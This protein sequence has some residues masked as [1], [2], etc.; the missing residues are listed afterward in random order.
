VSVTV[1]GLCVCRDH[2]Q[3]HAHQPA[4]RGDLPA[5]ALSCNQ[6]CELREREFDSS[7]HCSTLKQQHGPPCATDTAVPQGHSACRCNA[8]LLVLAPTAH[9]CSAYRW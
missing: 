9:N 6:C 1:L 3:Q 4:C 7:D 5:P 2:P 8:C